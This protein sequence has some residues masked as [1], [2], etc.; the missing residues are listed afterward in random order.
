MRAPTRYLISIP[1]ILRDSAREN[2]PA[3]FAQKTRLSFSSVHC[4]CPYRRIYRVCEG[5]RDWQMRTGTQ[6]RTY[7]YIH[8]SAKYHARGTRRAQASNVSSSGSADCRAN[9]KQQLKCV[10][11]PPFTVP[12]SLSLSFSSSPPPGRAEAEKSERASANA[13]EKGQWRCK[14]VE[15]KSRS[16]SRLMSATA[17]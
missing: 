1:Y 5:A 9:L 13:R 8:E 6:R 4:V 2:F 12:F 3:R 15:N 17:D 11:G 16:C 7:I 14:K 10:I